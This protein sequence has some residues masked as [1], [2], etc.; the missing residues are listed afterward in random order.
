MMRAA[1]ARWGETRSGMPEDGF[2]QLIGEVSGLDLQ[3][4]LEAS[5]LLRSHGIEFHTRQSAGGKDKGGKPDGNNKLPVV[6]LGAEIINRDGK[7]L[8]GV[9]HNG[10]P[11]E[12]AGIAPGDELVALD[13]LRVDVA[14]AES[15]TRRYRPGDRS[16]ISVFRGDEL[17]TLK[18]A[19]AEAPPDTCYLLLAEDA[20]ETVRALRAAWLGG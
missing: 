4:F 9:V 15:R 5:V 2:E 12:R 16:E 6:W 11:A 1:W 7:A 19:W 14:G 13:G 10:G 3:D 20:D 17:M 18:L 8:I